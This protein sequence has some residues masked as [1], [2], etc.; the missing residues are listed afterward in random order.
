MDGVDSLHKRL[1]EDRDA[2]EMSF[3]TGR[4]LFSRLETPTPRRG[5]VWGANICRSDAVHGLGTAAILRGGG[6]HQ[7]AGFLP[8]RFAYEPEGAD[9]VA[10]ELMVAARR[11][12]RAL[13]IALDERLD[14]LEQTV[15]RL[16]EDHPGRAALLAK[17]AGKRETAHLVDGDD[18][19]VAA[20]GRRWTLEWLR[21]DMSANLAWEIKTAAL[22][23]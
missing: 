19:L 6:F 7:P 16:P 22:F 23:K 20:L 8:L 11:E 17:L 3:R 9:A 10:R 13:E 14:V 5:E 2:T 21:R 18:G 12:A 1:R 4:V 15:A